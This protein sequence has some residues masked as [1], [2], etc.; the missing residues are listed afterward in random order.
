MPKITA[1]SAKETNVG[2]SA[3][4]HIGSQFLLAEFNSIRSF[5]EQSVSIGDKRVDVFLTLSSALIAGLGLFSQSGIDPYIFLI[6]ALCGSFG[7]FVIGLVTYHQVID[8]DILIIDYIRAINRIRGY[9]AEHAPHI[10][11]YLLMPTS[12]TFPKYNWQSSNRRIPM[13]INGFSFGALCALSS[14]LVRNTTTSDF[15]SIASLIIAFLLMYGF[16]EIYA[17]KI[18]NKAEVKAR[19]SRTVSLFES[20]ER[21]R[22]SL[23]INAPKP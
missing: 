17:R 18:F 5:K 9:F 8:R 3:S 11:P 14:L 15:I 19:E 20:H 6:I 16:Q 4:T 1:K 2:Q 12:L 13:V 23:R 21:F 22:E 10:Q 7:L